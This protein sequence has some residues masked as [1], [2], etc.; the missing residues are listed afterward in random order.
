MPR[1]R[2]RRPPAG[3]RAYPRTLRALRHRQLRV[4]S[5]LQRPEE[6]G[7]REVAGRALRRKLSQREDWTAL[8]RN[9][10]SRQDA[11]VGRHSEGTDPREGNSLPVLRLSRTAEV[12]PELVR[13]F[14]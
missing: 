13:R 3:S 1:E 14:G 2:P 12:D 9:R 5:Q 8:R 4:R 7:A 6:P 11:S 10:W